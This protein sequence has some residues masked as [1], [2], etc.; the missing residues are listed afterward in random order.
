LR[1]YKVIHDVIWG[2]NRF[3]WRELA[4]I[5]SPLM[6]RLREIHQTGLAYYVYP[7]ARHSRFEHSLGV[8]TVASRIFDALAQRHAA[9]LETI[10]GVLEKGKSPSDAIGK[11]RAE[12]RLAAL[13]HDT[14]HSLFSHT[15][16]LVYEKIQ[17]L[18]E[19]AE[20]LTKIAA[21]KKGAGE[22]LSFCLSQTPCLR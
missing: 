1:S 13:L 5:D 21:R 10:A 11:W 3:S 19:A 20:E 17:L 22:V 18:D 14:G 15:S 6:Q 9:D 7:C 8:A 4:I 2:T 16:E 12:L